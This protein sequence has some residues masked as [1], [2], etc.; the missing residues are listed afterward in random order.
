MKRGREKDPQTKLVPSDLLVH[1]GQL[2]I[3]FSGRTKSVNRNKMLRLASWNVRTLLD[4]SDRH[5][6]RTAIIGRELA[7]YNIDIAALSETRISAESQLIEVGAGYTFYTIGQPEGSPRQAGVGFAIK[8]SLIPQ[9]EEQPKGINPRL[10]SMKLRLRYGHSAVLL[11]AYAPTML[12]TDHEKEVFYENL[13]AAINAV[14]YRHRLFVLGDFNARVG[15][16]CLTW[17]RVLGHHSVGNENSNGTLLLQTCSQHELVITNTV[18][19]QAN[20]YKTTWMHPRSKHWHML[21]HVITRRRDLREVH[22]TRV[23]RGTSS[24]SDHR[25]VRCIVALDPCPPKRR[26]AQP[27]RRRLDVSRLSIP[28]VKHQ[29]Q[30]KLDETLASNPESNVDQPTCHSEWE[31]IKNATYKAAAEVLGMQVRKHQDWFDEQDD[32][33]CALLDDMHKTHLAWIN[34]KNSQAKKS[35]YTKARQA[36]QTR[37]RAMQENWWIRKAQELQ[38]AADQHDMKRFY[39]GLKQVYGPRSTGS[40]PIHSKDGSTLIADREKILHRWAEH[41][42]SVLNQPSVFDETVLD[43]IPQLPEAS[44]LDQPPTVDDVRKAV[45]QLS[46]GKSPGADSIPSEIYKDGGD[47][48]IQR[49]S[50]LF[51]KIWEAES[52]PQDFKDAQIVH[53]FKRKGDR[54]CCDNHRGISL[55]SIAGKVLARILLNRLSGYVFLQDIVPESQCGFRCGRGT[56]DMIF[57]VRQIQEKC[58]EQHRDLYMVFI[59]L[60]KAFDTV[61]REGLWQILKKIGCPKKFVNLI[62][63]FHDGMM[64][65]VLDCGEVSA[66]F[67]VTHGTKQGCVLAP[68]LFSIFFSMMLL[69]AFK[70]CNIG[71]PIHFRTDG[72]VF[73]LSRL[74]AR[75]KVHAA[76]IRDL[77]FAD[78]CALT[79]HSQDMA[80]QLFDRFANAAQRFGLTVS[81]KKTEVLFQPADRGTHTAPT[82]KAGVTVLKSVDRFCYLGSVLSTS[83]MIDDDVSARLAKASAAFG[84]LTKRLW[85]NHG[86]QLFT[87]IAVYRAV[88]LTTLLYGCESWT[89]Y[90]RHVSKLDQFHLRCLRK[91]AHIRWQ[92]MIPNTTVLERCNTWGIEAFLIA[93]QLRW[94]GHVIRMPDYRIPKQTFYSQLAEGA[95]SRGGQHKRYKDTLKLHLKACDIPAGELESLAFDRVNWRVKCR[96]GVCHFEEERIEILKEK[97]RCRKEHAAA[98]AR[99]EYRCN[100]CGRVCGSRIGLFAHR[101]THQ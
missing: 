79:A 59:D 94:I 58:R 49:L 11:S 52:V 10:M 75:T 99:T 28:D 96:D 41:F 93:A 67:R 2:V 61:N 9:L 12:A 73:N 36:A 60:T 45:K 84:R 100:V 29:L 5:E 78:D 3:Q 23:M 33:A 88:V 16:D 57:T 38:E 66:P 17:P 92:D 95:R 27:R 53:I 98:P 42:E 8:S 51:T 82:I 47:Q 101:R 30:R 19:Q 69:V 22:S 63:S 71:V 76:V 4:S 15:C 43:E 14:P 6:R 39:D 18:F 26:G 46:S 13:N 65:C 24:W 50:Q 68:L 72:N 62:R 77:L 31:A 37:L 89:L 74:R 81:L 35:V 34:D 21:D 54:A 90:R 83:A 32:E 80:Q 97:R 20:K 25:L 1:R 70:D 48:L 56:T 40:T 86:I 55:L 85:N 44:Y 91:I 7:R 64:G 87:K